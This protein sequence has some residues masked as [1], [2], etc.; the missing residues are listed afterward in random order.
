V[1]VDQSD[2]NAHLVASSLAAATGSLL[3]QSA[4]VVS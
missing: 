4:A 1:L 3:R 2:A